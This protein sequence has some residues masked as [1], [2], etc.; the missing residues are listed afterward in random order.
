MREKI[1]YELTKLFNAKLRLYVFFLLISTILSL[2]TPYPFYMMMVL[3]G[4]FVDYYLYSR[5]SHLRWSA[6][7]LRILGGM[8]ELAA[9]FSMIVA[10]FLFLFGG[11]YG[12]TISFGLSIFLIVFGMGLL[13]VGAMLILK[14]KMA[15]GIIIY[16]G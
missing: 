3:S 14:F 12:Y 7:S 15:S 1:K 10:F 8:C 2:I 13:L 4:I 16:R 9:A 5:A 11:I 6:F